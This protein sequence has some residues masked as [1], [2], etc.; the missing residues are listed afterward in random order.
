MLFRFRYYLY[1]V[2]RPSYLDC[3]RLVHEVNRQNYGQ[4]LNIVDAGGSENDWLVIFQ[5]VVGGH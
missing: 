2:P 5:E 1:E 4:A 3:G